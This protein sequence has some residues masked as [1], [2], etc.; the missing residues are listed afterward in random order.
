MPAPIPPHEAHK[1]LEAL[2]VTNLA[3]NAVR[4]A[5][6]SQ[7]QALLKDLKAQARR[8]Y[9]KLALEL[10]PDRTQGDKAK[11]EFFV[12]LGRVLEDLDKTTIQPAP[13]VP[14]MQ[15]A[16]A[17]PFNTVTGTG[18]WNPPISWQ[19]QVY[20]TTGTTTSSYTTT[21]VVRVVRMRP[22]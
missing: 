4:R 16:Y 18:A 1:A 12:L 10:H 8:N 3:L 7:A 19:Q 11:A 13:V 17:P 2:G 22:K 15:V 21:Q 6:F 20:A 14:R 9:K 5:P